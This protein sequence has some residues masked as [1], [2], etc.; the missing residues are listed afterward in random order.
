MVRNIITYYYPYLLSWY[1]EKD[2]QNYIIQLNGEKIIINNLLKD[3]KYFESENNGD[4]SEYNNN[5]FI[6]NINNIDYLCACKSNGFIQIWDLYNKKILKEFNAKCNLFNIIQWNNKFIIGCEYNF[7]DFNNSEYSLHII[8]IKNNQIIAKIKNNAQCIKKFYN[9]KYGEF[10]IIF[11]G[12]YI[13][14]W[15]C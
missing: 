13:S 2:S 9:N 3:N 5:G 7:I 14:L 12:N 15:K 1:N 10:L 11:D 8:D 6:Y 4:Y